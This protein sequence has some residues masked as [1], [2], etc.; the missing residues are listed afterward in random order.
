[1]ISH[2]ISRNIPVVV[3]WKVPLPQNLTEKRLRNLPLPQNKMKMCFRNVP[4]LQNNC[5]KGEWNY[6]N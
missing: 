2:V 4:L 3:F 1:M 5:E 6:E